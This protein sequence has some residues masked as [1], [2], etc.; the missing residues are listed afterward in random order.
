MITSVS[1]QGSDSVKWAK[2]AD[3]DIIPMWIADTDFAADG[4]IID[5]VRSRL[6]HGV[7]GYGQVT[8]AF[9]SAIVG[10][11]QRQYQWTIQ[12]EWIC[13]IPGVVPGLN[14]ARAVT[15]ARGK[16]AAIT[17]SPTYPHLR[18]NPAVLDFRQQFG[19]VVDDGDTWAVD[20][21]ALQAT[22]DEN[23]GMLMLCHPHNP[24]GKVYSD[25]ELHAFAALAKENDWIVCSDEI[26]C[27]LIL[28]GAQ[29]K[30]FASLNDDTLAR[31]ITLMAPSKTF[32]I[33]GLACAFA[34]IADETL[35][36]QFCSQC[37]GLTGDVNILGMTA[38]TAAFNQ[39]E[40]WRKEMI[41]MLKSHADAILEWVNS[42]PYLKMKPVQATF[43]AWID[44]R[45]LPVDKPQKFFEQA[46]VGLADGADYGWPG[47]VRLNFGCD[48]TVLE[49]A[50]ARM[51]RAIQSLEN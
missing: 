46:G 16:H 22:A 7:L 30:P 25:D 38:A 23:T 24:I 26:H 4:H 17:L 44:A 13:P 2:Y 12:P 40:P 37:A 29:H 51:A 21:P 1:R 20:F 19:E 50:L 49:Q 31:T 43:L 48:R 28:N 32:N 18:K 15:A 14:M 8:E 45:D 42:M 3:K 36:R 6:D 39:G 5:A 35:R 27:D 10:Y 47:F 9:K 34:V 33:A 41:A 11:L